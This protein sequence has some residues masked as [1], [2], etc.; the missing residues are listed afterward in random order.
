[1]NA[2]PQALS[3]SDAAV[4]ATAAQARSLELDVLRFLS[5][6]AMCTLHVLSTWWQAPDLAPQARAVAQLLHDACQFCVPVL[7]LV[8]L[9]LTARRLERDA[10]KGTV[11]SVGSRI[12]LLARPTF[13]WLGL[14]WLVGLALQSQGLASQWIFRI[15][16]GPSPL[17]TVMLAVHLW[18]MLVLLQMEPLFPRVHRAVERLT[19][20][21]PARALGLVVA[22]F[23]LKAA[24]TG[25]MFQ[26][27]R[28]AI[29]A[30]MGLAA[31]FWLDLMVL[32]ATWPLLQ[33]LLPS[34]PSLTT[35]AVWGLGLPALAAGL[36]TLEVR[37]WMGQG[38][39]ELLAH[40]NWR[41][42][43]LLYGVALFA[44]VIVHKDWLL[45]RLSATVS[46]GLTRFGQSYAYGFYLA[47]ALFLLTAE[48]LAPRLG[49][50][51]SARLV[52]ML[53]MTFGGT[54]ALLLLVSRTPR[55]G[56][57]LGVR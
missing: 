40:S 17:A 55:L 16:L 39:P 24:V 4:L 34:R 9:V 25:F 48:L 47:H 31:P 52:F 36:N 35:F 30:W 13:T 33:T 3:A 18:F 57:W 56:A 50:P 29:G 23:A 41:V 20:G 32:G 14:Y 54:G 5:L 1:M 19:A 2:Q 43:N 45:S 42:G 38:V 51:P 37:Y 7:F 26:P 27:S 21:R 10:A 22:V 6:T 12:G 15:P 44:A 8:S 28:A 53:V 11:R 46:M 49:W